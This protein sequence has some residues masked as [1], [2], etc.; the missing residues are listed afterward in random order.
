M[1]IRLYDL[2]LFI[3]VNSIIGIIITIPLAIIH[4]MLHARKAK[5]LGCLVVNKSLSQRFIKNET[6]VDTK[7]PEKIKQIARAPY[8]YLV[9]VSI[10]I[11][12]IGL[13]LN[14]WGIIIGGAGF[15][16]M[17]CVTYPIEGRPEKGEK[18]D[19]VENKGKKESSKS[20]KGL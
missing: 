1:L 7:D 2:I 3:I 17:Q 10:L 4:E 14:Q 16:L 12:V 13:Y 6:I 9:P 5:Q 20:G 19:L 11:L 15:L 8:F 18:N